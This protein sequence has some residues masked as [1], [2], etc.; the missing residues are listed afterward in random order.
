MSEDGGWRRSRGT[1]RCVILLLA[2]LLAL[3][4]L[5]GVASAASFL[6]MWGS[7]GKGN[8]QFNRPVAVAVGPHDDVFVV[9]QGN[10]RIEV[11]TGAGKSIG[12][13][14]SAGVA[15]GQF[16]APR[17]IA[18]DS[19]NHVYVAD[20]GNNRIEKFDSQGHVLK[21][22][23]TAGDSHGQF[24]QPVDVAVDATGDVYVAD[25]GNHRIQKFDSSGRFITT[26]G[27]FGSGANIPAD[28]FRGMGGISV[29]VQG[30]VFV[31]DP[32]E[33]KI[34]KFDRQGHFLRSWG[35][36]RSHHG[37]LGAPED[38]A[39]GK[40]GDVWVMETNIAR[41]VQRFDPDGEFLGSFG[42]RALD[43]QPG[44]GRFVESKGIAVSPRTGDVF[45]T[46]ERANTIQKF[47][48]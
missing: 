6:A 18:V 40:Q 9:D 46:D 17:G 22:W 39:T 35:S 4:T 10:S 24:K 23:G 27:K 15:G 16:V 12:G 13:W 2:S 43:G 42:T 31:T 26:W 19:H 28:R 36:E 30:D 44:P 25:A 33:F 20:T 21:V 41:R 5:S 38:L 47:A 8:G 3:V 32:A 7:T 48:P 29:S 1:C 37:S 34:K 11:F 14:G 45:V